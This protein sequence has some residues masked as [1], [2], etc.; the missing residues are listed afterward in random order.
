MSEIIDQAFVDLSAREFHD[1]L[2]LRVDVFVVEQQCPYAEVDGRDTEGRTRHIRINGDDG[3][4]AYLRLL[5]GGD[6]R[7]IGRVVT[8]PDHRRTGLARRL[9]GHVIARYPGELVLDSQSYLVGWYAAFGFVAT[10]PEYLDD[11]IAHVP[12][13]RPASLDR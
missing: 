12:M 5:D 6:S 8:R 13:H 1:V 10:G 11:G 9:V 4:I 2:R 7:R 3:P